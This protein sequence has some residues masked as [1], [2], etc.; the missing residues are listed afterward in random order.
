MNEDFLD[1][2]TAVL[3]AATAVTVC[4]A[5][6]YADALTMFPS[7]EGHST[8]VSDGDADTAIFNGSGIIT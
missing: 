7:M 2:R 4:D 5:I 3:A 1:H 8:H 6:G